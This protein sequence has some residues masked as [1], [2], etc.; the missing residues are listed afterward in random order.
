MSDPAKGSLSHLKVLD[1]SRV[2]A[3]PW[4]G[5]VL[6]DLGADV[7]KVERPGTGDDTRGW[8]PPFHERPDGSASQESGYYLC[9]NRGKRSVTVNLQEPEGQEIV[10]RLAREADILLENF[11]VGTLERFGLGYE[12][13]RKEN[14]RLIYCS[15][16]GYGQT[17]PRARQV[18]YDFLIQAQ[19]GMMSITG[20]EDGKPGGGP[21]KIGVPM[22][23]LTT[24]L[25][26][27]I[28]ILAAVARRAQTG[29]GE[30]IDIA[31]LDVQT[32][33]LAN[34]A[35]NHLLTGKTPRSYGNGHPNIM[36][37]QVFACIDGYM[38]LAV[39]NDGQ[40]ARL[41]KT[42]SDAE[43]AEDEDLKFNKGRVARRDWLLARLAGHFSR[44]N[45]ADLLEKLNAAG[46]P[47]GPINT[48][49]E[50]FDEPQ[51]KARGMVG[52]LTDP[53]MGEVPQVFGPIRMTNAAFRPD[54]PPP[55]LGADTADVL[56]GLGIGAEQLAM[57]RAKGIV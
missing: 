52:S 57:L 17:G 27:V 10:R 50:V 40:F 34:Q 35:M 38:V 45:R 6:A 36:P 1:L 12:S 7:I 3:G 19:G 16:T 26:S 18:A 53:V 31:M 29:E 14:P 21:Q 5:Q 22:V 9:C 47:A 32:S 51:V 33:L 43:L 44:Y 56:E 54:R 24:G 37:Q 49:P 39:G 41:C 13:L 11:K 55:M 46:V 25:Y 48:I 20:E 15:I 4:A 28:G 8:G 42:L 2:M 23:D 30:F